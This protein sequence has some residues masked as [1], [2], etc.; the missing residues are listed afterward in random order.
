MN[1]A[2][3][4]HFSQ[5]STWKRILLSA[6]GGAISGG[7]TFGLSSKY[8]SIYNTSRLA[9]MLVNAGGNVVGNSIQKML[10]N[11][12][13]DKDVFDGI[14]KDL[15]LSTITGALSGGLSK[16]GSVDAYEVKNTLYQFMKELDIKDE[17]LMSIVLQN[18]AIGIRDNVM[19]EGI[20]KATDKSK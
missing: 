14:D 4:Y 2:I 7:I 18:L 3:K 5:W 17:N 13:E 12:N 11:Y 6:G 15:F 19:K 10:S 9:R 20:D 1:K 8:S 16:N